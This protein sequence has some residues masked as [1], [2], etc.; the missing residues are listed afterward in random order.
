MLP[1]IAFVT[2]TQTIGVMM[3]W[4]IIYVLTSGGPYFATV[5]L[6]YQIY[7]RAFQSSKYGLAAAESI[8][9]LIIVLTLALIQKKVLVD[10][11]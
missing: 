10:R 3:I 8:I 7:I 1:I 5:S 4:Q 6:V 11:D 9:V 2:I